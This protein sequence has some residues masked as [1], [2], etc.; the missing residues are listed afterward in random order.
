MYESVEN[1]NTNEG[2]YD[3]V[4]KSKRKSMVRSATPVTNTKRQ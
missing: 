1:K 3:S 4:I 2:S